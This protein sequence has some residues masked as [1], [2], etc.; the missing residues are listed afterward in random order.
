MVSC[1]FFASRR[2]HTRCSLVTGVQ[3]CALPICESGLIFASAGYQWVNVKGNRGFSDQK[4]W[5]Y[6]LGLEVGPK[7]IGLGGLT[8]NSGARLRLQAQTYDFDSIRPMAGVVFHF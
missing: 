7:D 5:I 8:G 3:T 1:F 6:G 4:D 2:R